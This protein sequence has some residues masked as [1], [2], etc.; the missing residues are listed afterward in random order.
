MYIAVCD[1]QAEELKRSQMTGTDLKAFAQ[2]PIML[3]RP[4]L[5]KRVIIDE[6][7]NR[8]GYT[9]RVLL[10][11]TNT[12]HFVLLLSSHLGAFFTER[13]RLESLKAQCP[14]L[15][16]FPVLGTGANRS[17]TLVV[18][19][20]KNAYLTNHTKYFIKLMDKAMKSSNYVKQDDSSGKESSDAG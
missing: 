5:R 11:A 8:A 10:E 15:N 16:L 19:S 20:N 17:R 13:T 14:T 12:E 1:D 2:V 9:P 3:Q 6:L 7:F 4:G 18:V